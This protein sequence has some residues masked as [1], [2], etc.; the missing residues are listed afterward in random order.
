MEN[1]SLTRP[2]LSNQGLEKEGTNLLYMFVLKGDSPGGQEAR[3]RRHRRPAP[4]AASGWC[5]QFFLWDIMLAWCSLRWPV[6]LSKAGGAHLV[7]DPWPLLGRRWRA[8]DFGRWT[9]VF[10]IL[11]WVLVRSHWYSVPVGRCWE[12]SQ[13]GLGPGTTYVDLVLWRPMQTAEFPAAADSNDNFKDIK[14]FCQ[15]MIFSSLCW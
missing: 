2:N 14:T 10:G 3:L 12:Q 4:W 8:R 13:L 5:G 6:S 7:W 9:V 15:L 1:P 11:L